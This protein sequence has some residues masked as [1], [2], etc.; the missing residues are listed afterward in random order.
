MRDDITAAGED[1]LLD[2][3]VFDSLENSA[4][5]PQEL[6]LELQ[7]RQFLFDQEF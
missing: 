1:Q 4:K 7:I 3:I 6:F 2:I 5:R